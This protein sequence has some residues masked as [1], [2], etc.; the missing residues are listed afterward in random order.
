LWE[1]WVDECAIV[2]L[3]T[4]KVMGITGYKYNQIKQLQSKP[5][6]RRPTLYPTELQAQVLV[7]FSINYL[8]SVV[9]ILLD[10]SFRRGLRPAGLVKV[11]NS[12]S[13]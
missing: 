3:C 9:Y 12:N 8:L 2:A 13:L 11:A 5:M 7:L 4:P 1:F 10:P 6:L